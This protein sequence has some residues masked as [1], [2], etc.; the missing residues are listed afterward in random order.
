MGCFQSTEASLHAQAKSAHGGLRSGSGQN[1]ES[2]VAAMLGNNALSSSV[3]LFISCSG[4]R[5]LDTGSKSDPF[6]ILEEWNQNNGRW[7]EV[8]RS[9]IV[10][11][12]LNPAW[13]KRFKI[14]YHF[15]EIQKLRARVFDAD[16]HAQHDF[17][18]ETKDFVLADLMT[19]RKQQITLNLTGQTKRGPATG[20]CMLRAEEMRNQS[21]V[22]KMRCRG[23]KLAN[24]DG[25]FGKSDPFIRVSRIPTSAQ[26]LQSHHLHGRNDN[27]PIFKTEVVMNNLNPVWR[28]FSLSLNAL[29]NGNLERPILFEVFDYDRDGS[30]DLIGSCTATVAELQGN[31][32]V[33]KALVNGGTGK[34]GG[35]LAVDSCAVEYRASF[36][37]YI[38]HGTE[39]N[40]LVAI[41]F[42]GS[43]GNQGD[44]TSLHYISNQPNQYQQCIRRVGDVLEFYD[45]DKA[46]PTWGFGGITHPGGRA[47]HCFN[48]VPGGPDAKAMGISGILEAYNSAVQTVIL[49][50]PTIFSQVLQT[51]SAIAA[52]GLDGSQYFVLLIITDGV[53]T[54]MER[55]RDAIVAACDLPLSVLIVGV[56]NANFDRMEELDGDETRLKDSRGRQAQRDI[57]QFVAFRDFLYKSPEAFSKELLA[58]IPYQL[59]EFMRMKN[60]KPMDI[61]QHSVHAATLDYS[62]PEVPTDAAA[63]AA[64]VSPGSVFVQA[65]LS[66]NPTRL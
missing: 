63:A 50:G 45:N 23:I 54:D 38:T 8:G 52:G 20:M 22:V 5:N 32:P 31:G 18:G 1:G 10:T 57:V 40:F 39:I 55:T 56:G 43:N 60:L 17:A 42:T 25:L 33:R 13:V 51:A 14:Q 34:S 27:L 61:G 16:E 48:L 64:L 19:S 12:S 26:S 53:I 29:C 62:V 15:E 66:N 35:T 36:L 37:D 28:D 9:E 4:L 21:G 3:E 58:E 49:S 11:N 7:L 24:K 59:T 41:D 46:F 6:C 2:A 30:H 44:P 47:E 65:K